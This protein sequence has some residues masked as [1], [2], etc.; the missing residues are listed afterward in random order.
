MNQTHPGQRKSWSWSKNRA[1]FLDRDG[2]II[3]EKGFVFEP[4]DVVLVDAAAEAII[5]MSLMGL[6]IV[7]LTN[8]SG[9]GRGL[10]NEESYK[11]VLRRMVQLLEKS[12]ARLDGVY[13]CPHAPWEGCD[14]RKPKPDLALKAAKDLGISLSRS[15]VVG[16]K[17]SDMELAR[18]IGSKGILV[19]TGYG[20]RTE[21]EGN[22]VWDA[23]ADSIVG[24][25][26][27]I[28]KWVE[29]EEDGA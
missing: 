17:R 29:G 10:F 21:M 20:L 9:I 4:D 8:Q 23:V 18:T 13:H 2:V 11:K 6:K 1:V 28:Q 27:V 3:E 19:R 5:R 25:A 15:F 26:E 24:A 7:V 16:D 12:G 14:C 22:P